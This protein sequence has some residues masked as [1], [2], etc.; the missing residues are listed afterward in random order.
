MVLWPVSAYSERR[1]NNHLICWFCSSACNRPPPKWNWVT[2]SMSGM[3]CLSPAPLGASRAQPGKKVGKLV[4]TT[5]GICWSGG[6]ASLWYWW[7]SNMPIVLAYSHDCCTSQLRPGL[8]FPFRYMA[9]TEAHFRSMALRHMPPNLQK[10]DLL[11]TG[12]QD[13]SLGVSTWGSCPR[14]SAFIANIWS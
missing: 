10:V 13:L 5:H 9:N 12:K 1:V 7:W 4:L 11:K 3:L 8:L 6:A 2:L 14:F